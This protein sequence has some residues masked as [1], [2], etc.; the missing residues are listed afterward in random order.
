MLRSQK[1][2]DRRNSIQIISF[3]V[4]TNEAFVHNDTWINN[5]MN[6]LFSRHCVTIW[7]RCLFNVNR[8]VLLLFQYISAHFLE[9]IKIS[10]FSCYLLMRFFVRKRVSPFL[11]FLWQKLKHIA[12]ET[13]FL[14]LYRVHANSSDTVSSLELKCALYRPHNDI[15]K[16]F[17]L[18]KQITRNASISFRNTAK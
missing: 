8:T 18:Q 13:T 16:M 3:I 4:W 6:A 5:T 1:K 7:W 11:K 10:Q 14:T 12:P 15:Y 17:V 2:S 9:K